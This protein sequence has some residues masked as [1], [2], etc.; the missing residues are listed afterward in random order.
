MIL[1]C[2]PDRPLLLTPKGTVSRPKSLDLYE[3]EIE[4]IYTSLEDASTGAVQPPKEWTADS[5]AAYCRAVTN[6]IMR[7]DGGSVD[8]RDLFLQGCDSLQAT[9]LRNRL[10]AGLRQTGKTTEPPPP[11]WIYVNSTLASLSSSFLLATTTS[12]FAPA[13]ADPAARVQL[14]ETT[15]AR[16]SQNFAAH[17]GSRALPEKKT[18]LLTGATG[19]LGSYLLAKFVDDPDVALVYAV[20]RPAS[21]P[22][23]ER[24]VEALVDRGI[25]PSILKN[26]RVMVVEADLSRS[27]FGIP[28]SLFNEV[29]TRPC[30]SA[31]HL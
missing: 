4:A 18:V 1:V 17:S 24:Q 22:G 25:D 26:G 28:S 29:R 10:L 6:E 31:P 23:L 5:V 21:K 27:D 2:A 20:N 12:S 8:D 14:L 3:A 13:V 9:V 7:P 15:A 16:Y 30:I 19:T 11:N